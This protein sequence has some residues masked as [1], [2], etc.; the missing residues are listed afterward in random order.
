MALLKR[1]LTKETAAIAENNNCNGKVDTE[2]ETAVK[3]KKRCSRDDDANNNNNNNIKQE[4]KLCLPQK[5]QTQAALK[6]L[7]GSWPEAR[8]NPYR[9]P[10]QDEN[11]PAFQNLFEEKQKQKE[12][13]QARLN[14][15]EDLISREDHKKSAF[16]PGSAFKPPLD[17][18]R[19]GVIGYGAHTNGSHYATAYATPESTTGYMSFAPPPPPPNNLQP[20]PPPPP[21]SSHHQQ[22]Q[23]LSH[24]TA[25]LLATRSPYDDKSALET[26]KSEHEATVGHKNHTLH[27]DPDD[28]HYTTLQPA[29]VG[30]RAASVMQDINRD[31]SHVLSSSSETQVSSTANL[32]PQ[33]TYS[34][35]SLN[36]GDVKKQKQ[37]QKQR[38]NELA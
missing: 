37:K 22:Q 17:I 27:P 34:P 33:P 26:L 3:R 7:S 10:D 4:E 20:P 9:L 23:T 16:S 13:D 35:G 30:S 1:P 15:Q 25:S 32:I 11:P 14:T 19:N 18:K 5:K 8:N 38:T 31:Q 29:G 6:S 21:P 36:R 24:N 2:Y 28:K 12:N